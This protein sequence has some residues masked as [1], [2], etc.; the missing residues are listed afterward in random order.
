MNTKLKN[1]S[2][3]GMIERNRQKPELINK[4]KISYNSDQRQPHKENTKNIC[5]YD[6]T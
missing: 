2:L 4:N 1:I 5:L 6:W 3:R